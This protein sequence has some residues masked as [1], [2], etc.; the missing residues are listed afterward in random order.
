[1]GKPK[2]K[3]ESIQ[4]TPPQVAQTKMWRKLIKS[5]MKTCTIPFQILLAG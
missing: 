3:I 5:S 1:M 4:V 2:L